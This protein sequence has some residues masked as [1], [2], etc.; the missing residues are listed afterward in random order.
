MESKERTETLDKLIKYFS[1]PQG[2][3]PDKMC[4]DICMKILNVCNYEILKDCIAS[5]SREGEIT[6]S[7]HANAMFLFINIVFVYEDDESSNFSETKRD[8]LVFLQ[9]HT[10]EDIPEDHIID[11]IKNSGNAEELRGNFENFAK[12]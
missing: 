2:A 3:L 7:W 9:Y 11:I 6:L 1:T 4:L 12:K 5:F 8:I 10:I